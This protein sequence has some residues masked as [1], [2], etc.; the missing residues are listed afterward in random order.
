M[1]NYFLAKTEP[2]E[3]SWDDLV[4]DGRTVWSGV[5]SFAARRHLR[6]MSVGDRVLF[7]HS[8]A[9]R[10]VVGIATVVRAAYPDPT[11]SQADWSAVDLEPVTPLGRPV[12]LEQIK[13][14]PALSELALVRQPRLSV[15][16]VL[17]GHFQHILELGATVLGA[18]RPAS[19]LPVARRRYQQSGV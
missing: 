18:D 10:A 13:S 3:Y 5:R 19:P 9:A 7:Y 8:G 17:P 16:P 11:A 4:R 14:D 1:V 12:T 15:L 2:G 6:Q